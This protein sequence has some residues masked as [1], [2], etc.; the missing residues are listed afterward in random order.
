M[1]CYDHGGS[2]QGFEDNYGAG[3]LFFT[4]L[5]VKHIA[6]HNRPAYNSEVWGSRERGVH[7]LNYTYEDARLA[8]TIVLWGANSYETATVFYVEHMLPNL[9]GATVAEKQAAFNRGEPAE[10][11]YLIV[12][13]PRKTSS[14]TV[15]ETVAKDRVLLLQP[16]LGTDYILANAIAR[17][18]WE[19][20]YHDMAYLQAR[21]DMALFEEYKQKSLKLSVPYNQFMAEAERITGVPRA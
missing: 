13:D 18:V 6:I 2:G 19:K 7:E 5:S 8:D 11:G 17:A 3:K 12:I 14:Y 16:N 9:Q 15:A 20:G 21:T 10:P 4:A 1:K